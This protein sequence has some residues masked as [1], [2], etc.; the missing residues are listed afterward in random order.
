MNNKYLCM[1]DKYYLKMK[2]KENSIDNFLMK[3]THIGEAKL[4]GYIL[5]TFNPNDLHWTYDK[6]KKEAIIQLLDVSEATIFSY[7]KLLCKS[8]LLIKKGKGI[9]IVNKEYIEFGSKK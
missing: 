7:L 2:I 5:S 4:F 1:K 3:C 9:Y 8:Q 6:Y